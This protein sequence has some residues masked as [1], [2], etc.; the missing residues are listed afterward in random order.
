[1]HEN[2]IVYFVRVQTMIATCPNCEHGF[3]FAS[4]LAGKVIKCSKC[5][6]EC[7]APD[8]R[9]EAPQDAPD[10]GIPM[11]TLRETK[12]EVEEHLKTE[13][14]AKEEAQ[15][16]LQ[17]AT[18]KIEQL[19]K[20]FE[21]Q[22]AEFEGEL[23]NAS[24]SSGG[25]SRTDF[26][27]QLKAQMEAKN[28]LE[29]QLRDEIRARAKAEGEASVMAAQLK[30]HNSAVSRGRLG[31]SVNC[32]RGFLRMTGVVSAIVGVFMYIISANEGYI[33]KE[34]FDYP[35]TWPWNDQPTLFEGNAVV[36][37]ML[38]FAGVWGVYFLGRFIAKGFVSKQPPVIIPK[39]NSERPER[40]PAVSEIVSQKIGWRSS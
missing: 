30:L 23:R 25:G 1:M 7:R 14:E 18:E 31:E 22:K 5:S 10:D 12:A 11:A 29:Q 17:I 6:K 3:F 27:K 15:A 28:Q 37:G 4:D 34:S 39:Q 9:G 13:R 35:V 20:S 8:R 40:K 26:D 33:I 38:A 2:V 21:K 24:S 19:Q 16:K 36:M 32:K